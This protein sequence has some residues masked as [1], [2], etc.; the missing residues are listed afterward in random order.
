MRLT[1]DFNDF[2]KCNRGSVGGTD[3]DKRVCVMKREKEEESDKGRS[4]QDG[5]AKLPSSLQGRLVPGVGGW[6]VKG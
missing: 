2:S 1:L 6:E 5:A 3:K 4:G